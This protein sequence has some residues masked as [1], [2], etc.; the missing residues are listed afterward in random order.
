MR[1][2]R[3]GDNDDGPTARHGTGD[4]LI[5]P[6]DDDVNPATTGQC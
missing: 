5:G 2:K 6:S 1:R 4:E 3:P